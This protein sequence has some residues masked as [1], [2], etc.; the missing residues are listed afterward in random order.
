MSV[1]AHLPTFSKNQLG[2]VPKR[3]SLGKDEE[4]A[5]K[6]M[7]E[8]PGQ[9]SRELNPYWKD[10]GTGLPPAKTADVPSK[11]GESPDRKK[12]KTSHSERKSRSKSPERRHH[13]HHRIK[14]PE[15][16]RP[17][18]RRPSEGDDE[19]SNRSQRYTSSQ[20]S[21]K[22]AP[23]KTPIVD[24]PSSSSSSSSS[25]ESDV[26]EQPPASR[27]VEDDKVWTEQELNALNA[28]IIKAEI[29]GQQV[30]TAKPVEH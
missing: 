15:V 28:K 20:P 18:F 24:S 19:Y 25:E 12:H 23:Q 30:V 29:M 13:H 10:G 14:S 11:S 17:K 4:A 9:T 21:W 5:R 3:T 16:S 26:E 27:P 7:M 1:P 2:S 8:K 6:I 22:K